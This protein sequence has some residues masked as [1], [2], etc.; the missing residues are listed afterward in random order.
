MNAD[1]GGGLERSHRDALRPIIVAISDTKLL[2]G[3]H[4]GEWTFGP[5][6][7][8]AGIAACSMAQEEFGHTR[9]L[10]G[11]LKREFDLELDPLNDTR[12]PTEFASIAF[13]DHPF[14]SWAD[15]VAANAV[16]D[17]TLSLALSDF[18]GS[19]FEPLAKVVA[20]MLMEERFHFAHAEGWVRLMEERGGAPREATRTSIASALQQAAA[21]FGPPGHDAPL[22]ETGVKSSLDAALRDRLFTR[23]A[24]LLEDPGTVGLRMSNGA[25]ELADPVVW[26]GW[27]PARRRLD[28]GGPEP[29][30]LDEL[31]GTKNVAFKTA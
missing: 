5:P 2:L 28:P 24:R 1:R 17:Y 10:N 4:Y 8:E 31:R 25:W 26:A 7:I 18:E 16:V 21:F 3:Y 6:A 11:I 13:L 15:V 27:D 19:R 23:M 12:S 14:A 29:S 20:K 30:I 9:L 22:V